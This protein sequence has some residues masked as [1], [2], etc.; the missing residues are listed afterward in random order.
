LA[1]TR[2]CAS[3]LYYQ[4]VSSVRLDSRPNLRANS[5]RN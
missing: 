2:R 4:Y 1:A 3:S 5:S